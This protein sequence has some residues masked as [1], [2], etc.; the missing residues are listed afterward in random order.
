MWINIARSAKKLW[1]ALKLYAR[2]GERLAA[3]S[4]GSRGPW[5]LNRMFHA[6]SSIFVPNVLEANAFSFGVHY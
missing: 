3:A 4:A 6:F 1:E 2:N 5:S